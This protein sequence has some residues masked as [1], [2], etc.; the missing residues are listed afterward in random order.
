MPEIPEVPDGWAFN[1]LAGWPMDQFTHWPQLERAGNV[2]LPESFT[3]IAH[4][5][6]Q[7]DVLFLCFRVH[8][9]EV[10]LTTVMSSRSDVPSAL[11]RLRKAAPMDTWKRLAIVGMARFLASAD[12]DEL[13]EENARQG[14]GDLRRSWDEAA[15]MW[16][17]QLGGHAQENAERAASVPVRRR[18]RITREHLE[19]V[20]EVYRKADAEGVPPTRA[21][22][23][24][25]A[26]TH[27]TAAKWVA[28]AREEGLLGPSPGSRGG[29]IPSPFDNADAGS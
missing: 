17:T 28:K 24:I 13:A 12:P 1:V 21:V 8:E 16:Q 6:D 7:S 18:R 15:R 29:E 9:N 11:D 3:G 2:L 23:Q 19:K 26:T 5:D 27:S 22:Q 14:F 4:P 10:Q 25:F 20:V